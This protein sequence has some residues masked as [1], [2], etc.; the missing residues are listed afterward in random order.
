MIIIGAG[1][2]GLCASIVGARAGQR[3]LLLEQNNK[4]GKNN[5]FYGKN[6]SIKT[7]KTE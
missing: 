4:I 1:A 5:N 6:H 3:V 7:L 2:A